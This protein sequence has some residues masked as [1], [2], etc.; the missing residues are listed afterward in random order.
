[1]SFREEIQRKIEKKQ[2]E[3]F[4]FER[5]FERQRAAAEAYIQ[6]LQDV[7]KSLPR[8]ANDAKPETYLRAGGAMARTRELILSQ[9]RP[10]HV[11]DIL[12]GLGK[13]V[14]RGVRASLSTSL[15]TYARRGEVFVRTAPS[16]FGLL[17]LGHGAV[18]ETEPPAGFGRLAPAKSE[19][20][21]ASRE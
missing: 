14:E 5:E 17:E 21:E 20:M 18:T 11:N 12:K 6:A 13:P 3:W 2:A 4:E 7:L 19:E 10:L 15:N 1:M 9:R 8:D 16:T